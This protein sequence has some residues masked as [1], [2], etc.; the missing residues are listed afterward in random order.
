[1]YTYM[2]HT[3]VAHPT[4]VIGAYD[5]ILLTSAII[6]LLAR[7]CNQSAYLR[8]DILAR[9]CNQSALKYL[10]VGAIR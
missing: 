10:G 7:V 5:F 2:E 8:H 4:L 1:M 6:Y 9:V 3:G